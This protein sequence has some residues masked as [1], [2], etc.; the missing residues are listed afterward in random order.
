MQ[1][2]SFQI[3]IFMLLCTACK[4][5]S[6][7]PGSF[8]NPVFTVDFKVGNQAA[9]TVV[10]GEG[11][12]YLFTGLQTGPNNV[13]S[14]INTFASTDCPDGDCPGSLGFEFRSLFDGDSVFVPGSYR[15]YT[16]DSIASPDY[17]SID[18]FLTNTDPYNTW[19]LYSN[20]NL[21]LESDNITTVTTTANGDSTQN[22]YI[23]ANGNNGLGSTGFQ[24]FIPALA[25]Q[26]P[27]VAIQ[28][29]FSQGAYSLKAQT[30]GSPISEFKWS[31]GA[32][33][34]LINVDTVNLNVNYSITVTDIFGHTAAAGLDNIA[35]T[36]QVSTVGV[37]VSVTPVSDPLQLNRIVIRWVD[38]Q[39]HLWRSDRGGQPD[40][41]YF[42]IL[43]SA[44][45]DPNENGVSTRKMEVS[46]GCLLFD[47]QG[48]KQ[49]VTGAGVIAMAYP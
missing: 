32:T 24:S 31:T 3:F 15:Y 49:T 2:L 43:S 23:T 18:Y 40:T 11:G 4:K 34:S 46:F 10:A 28:S 14:S 42:L 20:G 27:A 1:K 45:Y 37:G 16:A 13:V 26:Y 21:L 6:L 17:Y 30:T 48:N 22:I 19:A 7:P 41:S 38:A 33:D 5:G 8:E 47:N 9:Q 44:P 25:F 36:N 12:F 29:S 39:N 35:L